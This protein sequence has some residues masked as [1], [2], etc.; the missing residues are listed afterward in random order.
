MMCTL[1]IELHCTTMWSVHIDLLYYS[2]AL[3]IAHLLQFFIAVTWI[4]HLLDIALKTFV[5]F[6]ISDVILAIIIIWSTCKDLSIDPHHVHLVRS[7]TVLATMGNLYGDKVYTHIYFVHISVHPHLPGIGEYLVRG[8]PNELSGC[9]ILA[10]QSW[11][12]NTFLNNCGR[13]EIFGIATYL[14]CVVCGRQG[15]APYEI[16]LLH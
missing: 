5:H 10:I 11:S 7:A 12:Y 9:C 16:R 13:G 8:A 15:H 1:H 4:I 3:S 14:G 2:T 6:E